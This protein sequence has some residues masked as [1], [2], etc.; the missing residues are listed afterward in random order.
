VLCTVIGHQQAKGWVLVDAGWMAM[1]RDRGTHEQP[2]DFGYG[3]VCDEDGAPIDGLIMSGA[4]QEHG[5]LSWRDGRVDAGLP[6]RFPVG[7]R[8]RI[9]PNHACATAAQFPAYDVL[10]ADG[11]LQRWDRFYGW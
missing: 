10:G 7:T 1:S 2:L 4:N 3:A 8:L 9:L 5:I 11:A 6:D